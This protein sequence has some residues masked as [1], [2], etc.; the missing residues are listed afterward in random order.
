GLTDLRIATCFGGPAMAAE[1]VLGLLSDGSYRKHMETVR[2]RLSRS[3]ETVGA[4]LR[5]LGIEPWI[6]PRAGMFLWCRLPD[7]LDAATLARHALEREVVLAPG[8]AF[9]LSGS[10]SGFLRFNAAQCDDKRIFSVL[11][12]ITRAP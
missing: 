11:E 3:R 5:N 9:S 1:L 8:N 4:R 6:E 10:A 7:G 12:E 2:Q